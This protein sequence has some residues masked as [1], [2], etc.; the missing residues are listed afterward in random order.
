MVEQ[1]STRREG[2]GGRQAVDL[3]RFTAML[4]SVLEY[5]H[6]RD[7]AGYSKFDALNSPHIERFATK[8][9]LRL[10]ATQAINRV[11]LPLRQ[12]AGVQKSRN[13]KGIANFIRALAL[14]YS[15]DPT[16]GL[17]AEIEK[18]AEWLLSVQAN[19]VGGIGKKFAGPCWGYNFPWQSPA[20]FAPRFYPNAIVT[21]F[22]AE[23]FL[24]AGSALGEPRFLEVA[25]DSTRY[26]LGDLP[27]L[28]ES[29]QAK[30]IGYVDVRPKFKVININAVVAGFLSKL[31]AALSET[32]LLME[33]DRLLTWVAG[34]ATPYHAWYY[35]H[36]PTGY[37]KDIDNYHT[38][39]ILD[40]FFDYLQVSNDT[41]HLQLF[42]DGLAFYE[43]ELFTADGAPKW[44]NTK[45]YP[46]DIHGSAQGVIT[47]AKASAYNPAYLARA[48]TIAEWA[49]NNLR[50][51]HGGFY[52]QRHR[53][54]T[55][56]LELM[57]WNNSWMSLA[58][59]ELVSAAKRGAE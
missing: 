14:K 31:G 27:I 39:G 57:R 4:D 55:W 51:P 25:R 1:A 3:T 59:A 47:F 53:F 29:P 18:L 28:E 7:Y 2:S 19:N 42:L 23:A 50:A 35:T 21:T 52:Y 10:V 48:A 44:R 41:R 26:L 24:A 30:C 15:Y 5:A 12:L 6:S 20:F 54:F 32:G 16:P 13:P 9:L 34:T 49:L 45:H 58:L 11:P 46:Y 38:G 22:C 8:P 17:K 36:P 43:R 40:G 56:E 33:A 37:V